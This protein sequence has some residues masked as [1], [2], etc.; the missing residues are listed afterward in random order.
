[1][2]KKLCEERGCIWDSQKRVDDIP[3]CYLD[4][5]KVGY[6]SINEFKTETGL[7]VNLLMKETAKSTFKTQKQIENLKFEVI[8]LTDRILRFKVLDSKNARY[9]VPFQKN[10]PL[11][12]KPVNITDENDRTYSFELNESRNDFSFSIVRKSTKTKL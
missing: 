8:Y 1:M 4:T 12:Q 10:F 9:E 3:I 11:L 7:V 2:E 6:K 5:K